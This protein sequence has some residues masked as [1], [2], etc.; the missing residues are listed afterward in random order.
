MLGLAAAQLGSVEPPTTSGHPLTA[1]DQIELGAVTMRQL[2]VHV[3]E[4][5]LTGSDTAAG[6][7]GR[8]H[9]TLPSWG[10]AD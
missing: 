10:R 1:A 8:R 4:K 2:G 9:A 7:S 5:V 3:G 6:S